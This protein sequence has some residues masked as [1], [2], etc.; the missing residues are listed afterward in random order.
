MEVDVS[1]FRY[2]FRLCAVIIA[3]FAFID[4]IPFGWRAMYVVGLVPLLWIQSFRRNVKETR[5]FEARSAELTP[6]GLSGWLR[7]L[8]SLG[9]RYPGRSAAVGLIGFL[10]SAGHT[11]QSVT[12]LREVLG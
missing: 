5:R 4:D 9:V 8:L 7:P 1:I 10:A 3:I 6:G 11:T 2:S 12:T